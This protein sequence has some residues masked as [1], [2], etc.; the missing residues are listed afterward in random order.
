MDKY[1]IDTTYGAETDR[2]GYA[3][4]LLSNEHECYMGCP[5]TD[6]ARHEIFFGSNR[7]NS[8]RTGM[9]LY[10]CPKCHREV[11][12]GDGTLD[13]YLKRLGQEVFEQTRSHEDFIAIFGRNYL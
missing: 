7:Q 2:N 11:H 1:F 3:P 13:A 8:K 6:V 4:S 5:S 10:L 9:W 12:Q